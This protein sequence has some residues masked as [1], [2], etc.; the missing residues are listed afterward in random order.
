MTLSSTRRVAVPA[1]SSTPAS[2]TMVTSFHSLPTS[3]LNPAPVSAYGA[4]VF[5]PGTGLSEH[6]YRLLN[7]SIVGMQHGGSIA[8]IKRGWPAKPRR[9]HS[10]AERCSGDISRPRCEFSFTL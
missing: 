1:G 3:P 10:A 7:G 8:I 6:F 4:V 2:I 5:G 9:I